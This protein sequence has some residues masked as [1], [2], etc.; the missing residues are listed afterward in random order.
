MFEI[1]FPTITK[2]KTLPIISQSQRLQQEPP[3]QSQPKS[4]LKTSNSKQP[5]L[6]RKFKSVIFRTNS[7][8]SLQLD[9]DSIRNDTEPEEDE[10]E[11]ISSSTLDSF[12]HPIHE[13]QT[14]KIHPTLLQRSQQ[15]AIDKQQE[16]EDHEE[17]DE[18]DNELEELEEL[19]T[20]LQSLKLQ[21]EST[22]SSYTAEYR[23]KAKPFEFVISHYD[24]NTDT[25]Q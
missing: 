1:I 4:I 18:N 3:P 17:K 5:L 10:D 12:P 24:N 6:L 21:Y 23:S 25:S 14:R 9:I 19:Q 20:Y 7:F 11:D 8:S 16:E 2:S 15:R 22:I 13:I